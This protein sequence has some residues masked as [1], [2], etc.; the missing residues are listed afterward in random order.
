M[1]TIKQQVHIDAKPQEVYDAYV[2]SKK[3]AEFTGASATFENKVGG[4]FDVWDGDLNG[5]NLE[6]IP[7]EKIVQKWR[8]SDWPEGHFSKLT[9]EFKPDGG[10][11]KIILTQVNVPDDKVDDINQGWHDYYWKPMNKYFKK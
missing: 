2:D 6:L 3:H 1:K 8:S 7:G 4:K 10:G 11:T 5:E 9:L